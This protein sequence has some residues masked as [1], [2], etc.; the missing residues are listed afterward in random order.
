MIENL[1]TIIGDYSKFLG[2]VLEE[3]EQAGFDFSDF[4]MI[5]HM[6]Y[7]TDSVETYQ[8]KKEDLKPYAKMVGETIVNGRP[9]S[10]FRLNEPVIH[11]NWRIDALELPAP[12]PSKPFLNGLEHI[13]FVLYDDIETFMRK[14]ADKPF[15]LGASNRGINPEIGLKLGMYSVKFHLLGLLAVVYI[16]NK[17]GINEVSS[18]D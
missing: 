2:E 15:E 6:C 18:D 12:K 10:T 7:R 9:I 1:K 14:Y 17:L 5:D 8:K 13:E 16:E 4:S 11:D 3:V